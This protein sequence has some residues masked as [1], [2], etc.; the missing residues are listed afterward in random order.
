MTQTKAWDLNRLHT[1]L[2]NSPPSIHSINLTM[3]TQVP[4]IWS[5]QHRSPFCLLR[6]IHSKWANSCFTHQHQVKNQYRIITKQCTTHSSCHKSHR[7]IYHSRSYQHINN[8]N[9]KSKQKQNFHSFSNNSHNSHSNNL[10]NNNNHNSS[11][12]YRT[13]SCC[14]LLQAK[15]LRRS[16][17]LMTKFK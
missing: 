1:I 3:V 14:F 7:T 15:S 5:Q 8:N 16:S 10:S 4:A 17:L 13:L 2:S 6:C 12:L 9:N 11:S